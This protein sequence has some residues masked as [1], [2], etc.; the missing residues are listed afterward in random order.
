MKYAIIK[1]DDQ[2]HEIMEKSIKLRT[3]FGNVYAPKSRT[4]IREGRAYVPEWVFLEAALNPC[5]MITG[6]EGM[7]S[8]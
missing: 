8:K 7:V 1:L 5:Q 2:N 6:Y 4:E 3:I